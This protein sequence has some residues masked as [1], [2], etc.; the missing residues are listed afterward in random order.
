MDIYVGNLPYQTDEQ[1]LRDLFS[2]YGKVDRVSIIFDKETGKSKGFAFVTMTDDTEANNAINTLNNK[3]L[4]GRPLK[5]NQARP[6]EERPQGG[7]GGQRRERR[8][9]R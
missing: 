9:D 3:D 6:R 4:E 1:R 8:F 5:V 2:A 7:G